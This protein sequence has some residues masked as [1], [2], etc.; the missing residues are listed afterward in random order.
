M[1]E[2]SIRLIIYAAI[3]V[4]IR[5]AILR[6][7]PICVY[8]VVGTCSASGT[9]LVTV[10]ALLVVV[11]FILKFKKSRLSPNAVDKGIAVYNI[12]YMLI[13]ACAHAHYF[14]VFYWQTIYTN[15]H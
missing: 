3:I 15:K 7:L 8:Y 1:L 6:S 14:T 12:D 2:C 11:A 10:L 5:F 4:I 13:C 9:L